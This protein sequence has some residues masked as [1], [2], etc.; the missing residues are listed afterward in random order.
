MTLFNFQNS[1]LKYEYGTHDKIIEHT[2][3]DI[4]DSTNENQYKK[5]IEKEDI[6][7]THYKNLITDTND[8][9]EFEFQQIKNTDKDITLFNYTQKKNNTNGSIF[10]INKSE[11]TDENNKNLFDMINT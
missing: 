7:N 11:I 3:Y 9:N 8:T 1:L 4:T 2:Q 10:K 6:I 5:I